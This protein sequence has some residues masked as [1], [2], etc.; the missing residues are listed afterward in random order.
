M[1][2]NETQ[3]LEL[4]NGNRS[5]LKQLA[6]IFAEDSG[7]LV[8]D[9]EHAILRREAEKAGFAIH[10]L[11]GIAATFFAEPEVSLFASIEM[12]AME[13]DWTRLETA[14]YQVR[15]AVLE[16]IREMQERSLL[17]DE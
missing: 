5:L 14:Q 3:A 6:K 1:T 15:E 8:D 12:A 7:P 13:S 9:F 2:I 10:S 17:I 4:L 11:K 16:I